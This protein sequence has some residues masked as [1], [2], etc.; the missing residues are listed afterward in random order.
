VPSIVRVCLVRVGTGERVI[1]L[2]TRR[3]LRPPPN[4]LELSC[5]AEAGKLSLNLRQASGRFKHH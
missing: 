2:H 3:Q 1:V 5:P 4:G